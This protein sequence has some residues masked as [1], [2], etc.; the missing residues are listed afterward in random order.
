MDDQF[1]LHQVFVAEPELLCLPS[2]K[3]LPGPGVLLS[4]GPGLMLLA[5]LDQRRP[6]PQADGGD[7]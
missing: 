4:L 7:R 2:L 1:G 3:F 5:W 6:H